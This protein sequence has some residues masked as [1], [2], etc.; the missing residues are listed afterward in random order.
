[1]LLSSPVPAVLRIGPYKFSFFSNENNE[2]RH[3]HAT[4]D[5][6]LAKFWLDP[7]ALA[8]NRGFADHELNM[9]ASLVVENRDRLQE[10]WDDYFKARH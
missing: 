3:V 1:L 7:V 10:A 6:K 4:R 8:M 5:S 9:V 2:P